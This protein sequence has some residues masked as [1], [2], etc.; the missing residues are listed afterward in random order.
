MLSYATLTNCTE[1]PLSLESATSPA[2]K[3]Q[4]GQ[5]IRHLVPLRTPFWRGSGKMW[6]AT[7]SACQEEAAWRSPQTLIRFGESARQLIQA[8]IYE[9]RLSDRKVKFTTSAEGEEGDGGFI[10]IPRVTFDEW[11]EKCLRWAPLNQS[12]T[13][14]CIMLCWC[15][16]WTICQAEWR[17]KTSASGAINGLH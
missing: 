11:R 15:S 2:D 13:F 10:V 5:N 7:T 6:R 12:V 9:D 3:W 17:L 16:S 4:G 14:V 1:S 8:I